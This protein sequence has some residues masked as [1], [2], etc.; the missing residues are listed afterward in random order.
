MMDARGG[1]RENGELVFNRYG[2][3]AGENEKIL[4][5]DGGDDCTT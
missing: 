3:S 2:V 5:M 4:K 1:G